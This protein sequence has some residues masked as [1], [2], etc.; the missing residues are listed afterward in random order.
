MVLGKTLGAE[1]GVC[2]QV[3]HPALPLLLPP[4]PPSSFFSFPTFS[5]PFP[6]S[7]SY[8][9]DPLTTQVF[10]RVPAPRVWAGTV[11]FPALMV[12]PERASSWLVHGYLEQILVCVPKCGMGSIMS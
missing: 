10:S 9:L 12:W 8:P 4:F 11:S 5:L 2:N 3:P 6:L 1:G 7:P